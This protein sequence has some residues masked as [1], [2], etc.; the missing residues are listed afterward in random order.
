MDHLPR[1]NRWQFEISIIELNGKRRLVHSKLKD[2]KGMCE[3]PSEKLQL[4]SH[5]DEQL[6]LLNSLDIK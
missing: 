2:D 4:F 6:K 3:S 1:P 5:I